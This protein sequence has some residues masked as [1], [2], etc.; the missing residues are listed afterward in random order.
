MYYGFSIFFALKLAG[1]WKYYC[2]F[3]FSVSLFK[4][5]QG[6]INRQRTVQKV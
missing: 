4:K 5:K 6:N 3:S 2:P 1:N